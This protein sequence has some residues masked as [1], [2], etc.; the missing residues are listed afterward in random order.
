MFDNSEELRRDQQFAGEVGD[1]L[2]AAVHERAL[3]INTAIP[4]IVV[5][6]DPTTQTAAVQPAIKRQ[7]IDG[8][9]ALPVCVDVPVIFPAG[10]L[11]VL[12]M[13]V[14]A[15]DECLLIFSQRAI[16]SWF[17]LGGV[18]EASEFRLHDL[19]DG[20]AIVGAFSTPRRIA[21]FNM[22]GPELRTMDRSTFIRLEAG[23][24]VIQ[25]NLVHTG[26]VTSNGKNIGSTHVHTGVNPGG[27]N[28]GAP[29]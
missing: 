21:A 29:A 3:G 10:G 4:G 11:F 15:G 7:F 16:D 24:I 8:V 9:A 14:Q 13:P 18:Q 28:S 27:G 25:G 23:Q 12:T 26:T 1:M 19:S 2:A 6:F 20:F 22:A 17:A 5:S